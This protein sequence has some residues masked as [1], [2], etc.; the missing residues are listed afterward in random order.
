M[1]ALALHSPAWDLG[2]VS[3]LCQPQISGSSQ[4]CVTWSSL[5]AQLLKRHC[6]LHCPLSEQ[7]HIGWVVGGENVR[8]THQ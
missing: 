1:L 4:S 8:H 3:Y 6:Q 2:Q 5:A 7:R